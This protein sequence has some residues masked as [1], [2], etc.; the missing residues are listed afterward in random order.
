MNRK[1]TSIFKTGNDHN[2]SV[3]F[4]IVELLI[5]IVVIGILAVITVVSYTGV[6]KRAQI[7]KMNEDLITLQKAIMLARTA[8]DK[9]LLQITGNGYS[10]GACV[11]KP[12]GTDLAS[13]PRTDSCWTNYMTVLDAVS[14][15]SGVNVRSMVDPWGR[16]YRVDENEGEGGGCSMDSTRVFSYPFVASASYPD[17]DYRIPLSGLTGC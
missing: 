12:D 15:A 3:G 9:T 11:G 14:D 16:P 2:F 6:Q 4:T 7:S 8:T 5:V 13:L 1:I 17:I 10:A